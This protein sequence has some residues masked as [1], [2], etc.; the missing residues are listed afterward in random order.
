M[1]AN[2]EMISLPHIPNLSV[3]QAILVTVRAAQQAM[4][5]LGS[6]Q[7]ESVYESAMSKTL[8]YQNIPFLT[9]CPTRK[10]AAPG[11]SAATGPADMFIAGS[12]VVELKAGHSRIRRE[13]IDQ[14]MR[15]YASIAEEHK[16]VRDNELVAM[17][18]N[19]KRGADVVQLWESRRQIVTSLHVDRSNISPFALLGT[20]T[21]ESAPIEYE[22]MQ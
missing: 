14:V 11:I 6:A 10:R 20:P 13:H 2:A 3:E 9:Q 16:E 12:L 18:I 19:F 8:F 15:Y 4:H 7:R 22:D 1:S 21:K 17:V 5:A